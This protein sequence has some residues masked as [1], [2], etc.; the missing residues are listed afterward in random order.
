VFTTE[1]LQQINCYYR[2]GW[3]SR[4]K[5]AFHVKVFWNFAS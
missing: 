3:S 1:L 5:L 2:S 4:H